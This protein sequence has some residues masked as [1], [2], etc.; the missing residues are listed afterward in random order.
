[1]ERLR[2]SSLSF[3]MGILG[4]WELVCGVSGGGVRESRGACGFA[5][6]SSI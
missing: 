2:V 1:M 4:S 6:V 3:G 5:L